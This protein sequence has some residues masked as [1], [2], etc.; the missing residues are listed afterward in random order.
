MSE[1][2]DNVARGRLEMA[3]EGQVVFAD[4][5]RQGDTLFID[6]VEAPVPLRGTGAAGRFMTELT[7]FAREEGVRLAPICSYAVAWIARH[8]S[9]AAG[10]VA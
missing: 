8:P 1:L 9:E 2:V 7:R 5:R 4:Y 6:H 3:V 10:L